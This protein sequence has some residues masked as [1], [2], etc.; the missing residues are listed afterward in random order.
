MWHKCCLFVYKIFV[1][2]CVCVCIACKQA[3]VCVLPRALYTKQLHCSVYS[4]K[5]KFAWELFNH[6]FFFISFPVPLSCVNMYRHISPKT[7]TNTCATSCRYAIFIWR[8]FLPMYL[9]FDVDSVVWFHGGDFINFSCCVR[10]ELLRLWEA[11][12]NGRRAV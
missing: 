8:T 12:L 5:H 2:A 10:P 1:C 3:S 11:E 6:F 4:N 7:H 9:S